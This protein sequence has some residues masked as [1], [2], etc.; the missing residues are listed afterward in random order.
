[1]VVFLVNGESAA[2]VLGRW[3]SW[4]IRNKAVVTAQLIFFFS[5]V[6]VGK[7]LLQVYGAD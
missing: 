3:K 1:M 2:T 5:F 6:L 4:P 7:R